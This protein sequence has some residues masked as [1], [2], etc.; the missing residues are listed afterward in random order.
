VS[1]S[2]R[3]RKEPASGI[4]LGFREPGFYRV[5]GNGDI[6]VDSRVREIADLHITRLEEPPEEEKR[7]SK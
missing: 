7:G 2:R 3:W 5:A 1:P 4:H 6:G